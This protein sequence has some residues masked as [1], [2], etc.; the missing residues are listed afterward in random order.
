MIQKKVERLLN[1]RVLRGNLE[2]DPDDE[3]KHAGKPGI[4]DNN[5]E[6]HAHER[7]CC[8]VERQHGIRSQGEANVVERGLCREDCPPDGVNAAALDVLVV[9]SCMLNPRNQE[10]YGE[11]VEANHVTYPIG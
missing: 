2:H 11:R 1:A 4:A 8:I 7:P 3:P 10:N 5:Q 9:A 6:R